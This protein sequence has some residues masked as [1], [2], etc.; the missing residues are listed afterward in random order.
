VINHLDRTRFQVSVV[1]IGRDGKSF[2]RSALKSELQLDPAKELPA[3]PSD[4]WINYLPTVDPE[5][6]VVLPILHGPYGEDGTVQGMLEVLG[7][8]YVGAGVGASAVGM[9]KIYCKSILRAVKIPVLPWLSVNCAEWG[10]SSSRVVERAE[11]ELSYPIFV[12]PANMGS[13]VG[14]NKSH[15]R[16]E[17]LEHVK[18]ALVYDDYVVLE[19][20]LDAREIEVSVLGSFIPLASVPGEI[21]P[22]E[23]FYSYEA[24]YLKEG[25]RLLIPAPLDEAEAEKI[26]E[27]S[28]K[29]FQALQLEGMARVDFLM[30]RKSGKI[31]V[32]E[33]NTIPGFTQISMYPKL[34]E[35]SGLPYSQLLE[36]MI[37]L[38]MERHSRRSQLSVSR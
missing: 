36:R 5:N 14:I 37:E 35:A 20:G 15:S 32:N 29:V 4:N 7:L 11:D 28:I 31:W 25:S 26:R 27:L 17:L 38:G 24:K 10:T 6:S 12:K 22:A 18:E 30:E 16:N 9:N 19:P 21:V 34:W 8:P 2:S 23:E 3:F 13:S 1:G 33:P